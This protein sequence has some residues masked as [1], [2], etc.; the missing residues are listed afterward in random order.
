MVSYGKA[1]WVC[2]LTGITSPQPEILQVMV[3]ALSGGG[4]STLLQPRLLGT[5]TGKTSPTP[6]FF[7]SPPKSGLTGVLF[8]INARSVGATPL[9]RLVW[10]TG[11]AEEEL[12]RGE[13]EDIGGEQELNLR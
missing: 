5:L 6:V 9:G 7:L 1:G 12:T 13:C 8:R 4:G 3:R 2:G 10:S 11:S